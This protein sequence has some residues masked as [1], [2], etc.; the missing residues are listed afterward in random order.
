[1]NALD[2]F[3]QK[4]GNR[5]IG[6]SEPLTEDRINILVEKCA[7]YN[8]N[9]EIINTNEANVIYWV[10]N[11]T[12]SGQDDE[13]FVVTNKFGTWL[14]DW[15]WF[16]HLPFDQFIDLIEGKYKCQDQSW[17]DNFIQECDKPFLKNN[18]KRNEMHM[19]E[20]FEKGFFAA[21]Q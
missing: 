2:L 14:M 1:M 21:L 3:S 7:Q 6:C 20:M 10:K 17:H 15:F 13:L 12:T 19:N 16:V 11:P 8:I 5:H 18:A 4:I 9:C